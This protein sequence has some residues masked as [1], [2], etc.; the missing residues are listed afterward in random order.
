MQHFYSL[1]RIK[2]IYHG[3]WSDPEL[4][5]KKKHLNYYDVENILYEDFM[6]LLINNLNNGYNFIDWIK[7][8][9]THCYDLIND[10]IEYLKEY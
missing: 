8:N 2:Y 10:S 1:K 5:Y 9:K 6:D 7:H 4:I 3:D